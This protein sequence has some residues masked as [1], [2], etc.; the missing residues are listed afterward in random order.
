MKL[1]SYESFEMVGP[2]PVSSRVIFSCVLLAA[3]VMSAWKW[4]SISR[5]VETRR[6][7]CLGLVLLGAAGAFLMVYLN[8]VQILPYLFLSV[9]VV[10]GLVLCFLMWSGYLATGP[11]SAGVFKLLLLLLSYPCSVAEMRA[12]Y[13]LL[14]DSD[15]WLAPLRMLLCALLWFVSRQPA[16][17]PMVCDQNHRQPIGVID[18][19]DLITGASAVCIVSGSVIRGIID[20]GISPDPSMRMWLI[21]GLGLLA[22][23]SVGIVE[24]VNRKKRSWLS[25]GGQGYS[26]ASFRGV[27][28]VGWAFSAFAFFAGALMYLSDI[29]PTVG[30]YIDT[31]SCSL[32]LAVF[33]M[34]LSDLVS[35]DRSV[36]PP[37][38]LIYGLGLW[39]LCW[40]LSYVAIPMVNGTS[41]L[42][43]GT[44]FE[45][46]VVLVATLAALASGVVVF[47]MFMARSQA[48][49]LLA[50][51][52][53]SS[54]PADD[55]SVATPCGIDP[56]DAREYIERRLIDDYALTGREAQVAVLF[57]HGYSL[58]RVSE[59]LQITKST[60]QG[61]T[62][63]IYKKLGI[64]NKNEL[65]DL[66]SGYHA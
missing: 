21:V 29:L 27:L 23:A 66:L 61:Y 59:E 54:A 30:A 38:Y 33:Y 39:A 48:G 11:S 28:T 12:L 65:I 45:S 8:S 34:L 19:G 64:H 53:R 1:Y 58:G 37:V 36:S 16:G 51:G 25:A 3:I 10:C 55:A 60:A 7:A 31:S 15:A 17:G 14:G 24:A 43:A 40:F 46:G 50:A 47:A 22:L 20:D 42:T 49:D 26:R 52:A 2:V 18:F 63:Q 44:R 57:A 32:Q 41:G 5:L 35:V 9:L 62:K 4:R 13:V 56:A 6:L